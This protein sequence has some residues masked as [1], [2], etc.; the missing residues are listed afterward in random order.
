MTLAIG[1]V[2]VLLL[3]AAAIRYFENSLIYFPPRFPQGFIPAHASR[4]R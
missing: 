4:C 1:V 3:I 2:A